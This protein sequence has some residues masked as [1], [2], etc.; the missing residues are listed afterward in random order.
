MKTTLSPALSPYFFLSLAGITTCPLTLIIDSS[1]FYTVLLCKTSSDIYFIDL[2][3]TAL[4]QAPLSS[5]RSPPPLAPPSSVPPA[6]QSSHSPRCRSAAADYPPQWVRQRG[7]TTG[8][9][10]LPRS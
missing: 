9:T 2:V 3:R 8:C 7:W 5:P 4:L 10:P 6:A 1:T